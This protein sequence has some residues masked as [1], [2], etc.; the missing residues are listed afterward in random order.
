[1]DKMDSMEEFQEKEASLSDPET[2]C[3]L[4]RSFQ[5]R[6]CHTSQLLTWLV[7]WWEGFKGMHPQRAG[8][9]FLDAFAC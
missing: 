2:S 4:V 5:S 9:I 3:N 1:M 7:S 8:Q 6:N